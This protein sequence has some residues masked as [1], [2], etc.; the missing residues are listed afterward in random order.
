MGWLARSDIIAAV[1]K[2]PKWTVIDAMQE[3]DGSSRSQ[4]RADAIARVQYVRSLG[5]AQPFVVMGPT[6]GRDLPSILA[7]GPAVAAADPL[8]RTILG[9]QAY[10]GA[11]GWYQ[12][13]YGMTLLEGVD[14]AAAAAF[15][16]QLGILNWAEVGCTD[17]LAYR[18]VMAA[19]QANGQGWM[20][21]DYY[22]PGYPCFDVTTDGRAT[23]LTADGDVLVN[24][25]DGLLATSAKACGQ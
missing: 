15:P 3:Y 8:G 18:A 21:W 13:V 6:G 14:Q 4:W 16:I 11:S 2:Y 17:A 10:W 19:A 24:D 9:W 7:A 23:S 22:L 12:G 1:N 25:P 20:W 5:Y